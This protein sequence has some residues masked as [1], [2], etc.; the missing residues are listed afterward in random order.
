[1]RRNGVTR[2][3]GSQVGKLKVGS[4]HLQH[5]SSGLP[6]HIHTETHSLLQHTRDIPIY[7]RGQVKVDSYR[8]K[9]T[10]CR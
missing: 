7:A 3:Y 4:V 8:L 5:V 1:M 10:G 2:T 6:E 9:V